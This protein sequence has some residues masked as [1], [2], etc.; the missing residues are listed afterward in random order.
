METAKSHKINIPTV[1]LQ[2]QQG[3]L[4]ELFSLDL[5]LPCSWKQQLSFWD[6]FLLMRFL[7]PQSLF[8]FPG[9]YASL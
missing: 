9:Y 5:L 3:L 2:G 1:R 4:R 6:Q 8:T 7:F